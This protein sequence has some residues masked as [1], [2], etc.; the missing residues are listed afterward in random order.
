ME[1]SQSKEAHA[2]YCDCA[3]RLK[4]AWRLGRRLG[5]EKLV[6]THVRGMSTLVDAKEVKVDTIGVS[7]CGEHTSRRKHEVIKCEHA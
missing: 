3:C 4:E 1:G 5:L 6:V 2:L 7:Q